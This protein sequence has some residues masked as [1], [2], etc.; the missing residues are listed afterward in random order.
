MKSGLEELGLGKAANGQEPGE[1]AFATA[2][3]GATP[4]PPLR[5]STAMATAA[6]A[7]LGPAAAIADGATAV[8]ADGGG[9]TSAAWQAM[10]LMDTC[11]QQCLQSAPGGDE[12]ASSCSFSLLHRADMC[13]IWTVLNYNTQAR[14]ALCL[15]CPL[16]STRHAQL[17]VPAMRA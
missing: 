11:R 2:G 8:A 1:M 6:G 13:A 17:A 4:P 14:K 5:V 9:A 16:P 3:A 10:P 7:A 12:V 15:D